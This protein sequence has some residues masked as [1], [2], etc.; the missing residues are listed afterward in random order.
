VWHEIEQVS[1][2]WKLENGNGNGKME[3]SF[4]NET[5]K[6]IRGEDW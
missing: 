4:L 3:I 6:L 2:V 5:N 1:G